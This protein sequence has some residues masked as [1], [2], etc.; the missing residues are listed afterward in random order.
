MTICTYCWSEQGLLGRV[1]RQVQHGVSGGFSG[2]G[3]TSQAVHDQVQPQ[4]LNSRQGAFLYCYCPRHAVVTATILTVSCSSHT[5]QSAK[6]CGQLLRRRLMSTQ[7]RQ[8]SHHNVD[9]QLQHLQPKTQ[10]QHL[11]CCQGELLDGYRAQAGSHYVH[12]KLQQ[13]QT[14]TK[15]LQFRTAGFGSCCQRPR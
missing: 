10:P 12:S 4:H 9:G 5:Q 8:R 6:A 3:Q 15:Q 1:G 11:K 14:K 13:S 7:S 2:K